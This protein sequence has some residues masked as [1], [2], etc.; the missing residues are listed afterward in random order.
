MSIAGLAH[1]GV[2][3]SERNLDQAIRALGSRRAAETYFTPMSPSRKRM[4]I[5]RAVNVALWDWLTIRADLRFMAQPNGTGLRWHWYIMRRHGRFGW[6]C[7]RGARGR[8]F[9]RWSIPNAQRL[10]DVK[11]SWVR[12]GKVQV[13]V[14]RYLRT[15]PDAARRQGL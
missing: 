11:T 12:G 9:R 15:P 2:K 7:S 6:P 14:A 8:S 5:G 10:I 4:S 13:S 3:C 1:E